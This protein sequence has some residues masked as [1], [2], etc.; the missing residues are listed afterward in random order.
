MQLGGL[1]P[2]LES[3]THTIELTMPGEWSGQTTSLEITIE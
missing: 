3:G 2:E 1:R